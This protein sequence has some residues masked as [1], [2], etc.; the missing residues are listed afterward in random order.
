MSLLRITDESTPA[1][2]AEAI[3]HLRARQRIVR[4]QQVRD[5]ISDAI[6]EML[7]LL[8]REAGR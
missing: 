5:E 6:D 3:S 1:D 8:P 2:I 4:D 7:D